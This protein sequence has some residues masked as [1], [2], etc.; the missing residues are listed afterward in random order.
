MERFSDRCNCSVYTFALSQNNDFKLLK[1]KVEA[2]CFK[3]FYSNQH[4]N[5][6]YF[7]FSKEELLK[8]CFKYFSLAHNTKI[9][10]ILTESGYFPINS[11]TKFCVY[12]CKCNENVSAAVVV[13]FLLCHF[14]RSATDFTLA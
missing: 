12:V 7:L 6:F 9:S 14:S 10:I 4:D 5:P 13:S 2:F 11:S 8:L 1:T 3:H